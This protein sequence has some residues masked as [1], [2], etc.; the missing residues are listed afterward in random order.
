[1]ADR[2]DAGA[3]EMRRRMDRAA[4]EDD[5]AATEFLLAAA[6]AGLTTQAVGLANYAESHLRSNRI[7]NGQQGWIQTR[8]DALGDLHGHA[9]QWTIHLSDLMS[10]VG[11][12]GGALRQ[13]K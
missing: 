10:L 6:D 7:D 9:P 4:G 3:Q 8:L 5:L 1:M 11:E 13:T 12:V 2:A